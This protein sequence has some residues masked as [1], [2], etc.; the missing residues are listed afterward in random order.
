MK[1][2]LLWLSLLGPSCIDLNPR[3]VHCSNDEGRASPGATWHAQ[4]A[5]LMARKCM[6]CHQG[7]GKAPMS[8]DTYLK[9][10][11]RKGSVREAVAARHMP[12]WPPAPCCAAYENAASLT[13]DERALLLAWLDEGGLEGITVPPPPI[14]TPLALNADT[15]LT[16]PE[17]VHPFFGL[18]HRRDPMLSVGNGFY[19]NAFH[20][21]H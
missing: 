15:V 16:M 19:P 13:N 3:A 2:L 21:W 18:W 7:G 4:V 14:P 8:L 5:P 11:E 9:V 20:H 10:M 12:P 6:T 1:L 17:G